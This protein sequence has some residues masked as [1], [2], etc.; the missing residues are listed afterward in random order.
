MTIETCITH[1]SY[2]TFEDSNS[3]C[4]CKRIQEEGPYHRFFAKTHVFLSSSVLAKVEAGIS[5]LEKTITSEDF[6]KILEKEIAHSFSNK[7]VEGGVLMSYDFHLDGE[8]PKLIEINTNA[9]GAF[10]NYELAKITKSCCG[11]LSVNNVENFETDIVAM[12][13]NEFAK[14]SNKNLET[15]CIVDENPEGQFLYPEFLICKEILERNG[16]VTYIADPSLIVIE[17]GK[18]TYHGI[19]ID[20]IYNLV[21]CRAH[22]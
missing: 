20:F 10:L 13:R 14:K 2:A 19:A 6:K 8:T 21:V 1:S 9:G 18:A 22:R 3:Q 17:N 15:V 7:D 4:L 16:I 5:L 12:F 11:K